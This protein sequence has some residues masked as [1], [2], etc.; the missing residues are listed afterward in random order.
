MVTQQFPELVAVFS[1]WEHD[2]VID[3]EILAIKDNSVLLFND[4]QKRLN[5]KHVSKKLIQVILRVNLLLN[6][7]NNTCTCIIYFHHM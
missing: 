7:S 5:R 2:F 1:T 4:L 3:G 6:T